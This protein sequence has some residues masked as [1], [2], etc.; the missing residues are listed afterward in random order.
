MRSSF[1][2]AKSILEDSFGIYNMCIDLQHPRNAEKVIKILSGLS[3]KT[4]ACLQ[5][6]SYIELTGVSFY[7]LTVKGVVYRLAKDNFLNDAILWNE[8]NIDIYVDYVRKNLHKVKKRDDPFAFL[9]TFYV[10]IP[11]VRGEKKVRSKETDMLI[12]KLES[13]SKDDFPEMENELFESFRKKIRDLKEVEVYSNEDEKNFQQAKNIGKQRII[14]NTPVKYYEAPIELLECQCM[15]ESELYS[16]LYD[17]YEQENNGK[18]EL[19]ANMKQVTL[20]EMKT[21]AEKFIKKYGGVVSGSAALAFYNQEH[22]NAII[23][24][25]LP[26]DIDVI[27]SSS[28]KTKFDRARSDLAQ[29]FIHYH[30]LRYDDVSVA[31]IEYYLFENVEFNLIYNDVVKAEDHIRKFD[32]ECRRM[33]WDPSLEDPFSRTDWLDR[34]CVEYK[35]ITYPI[36]RRNADGDINFKR[37]RKYRERGFDVMIVDHPD[38]KEEQQPKY[39]AMLDCEPVVSLDFIKLKQ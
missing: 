4:K 35:K 1:G 11:L 26:N 16:R 6:S 3:E 15:V 20:S 39:S 8:R 33:I 29:S 22:D 7:E 27:F 17:R 38:H 21:A 14:T 9:S 32:M 10:Y 13:F 31:I 30:D 23:P 12:E 2:L 18:Q 24:E 36:Q 37:I 5:L 19:L 25:F 28:D 34:L